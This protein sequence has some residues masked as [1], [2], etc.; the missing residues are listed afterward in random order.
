MNAKRLLS[1]GSSIWCIFDLAKWKMEYSEATGKELCG[2]L[3]RSVP[4]SKAFILIEFPYF[5]FSQNPHIAWVNSFTPLIFHLKFSQD[6]EVLGWQAHK[7]DLRV[8]YP[9]F[10]FPHSHLWAPG[11]TMS[12]I[13]DYLQKWKSVQLGKYGFMAQFHRLLAVWP[14]IVTKI[15]S[16][17]KL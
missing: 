15:V 14:W 6:L 17:F 10:K 11:C 2:H 9:T 4:S 16:F 8:Q 13:K 3:L 7:C 12:C 1:F 5:D